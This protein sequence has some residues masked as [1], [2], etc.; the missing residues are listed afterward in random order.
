MIYQWK[1]PGVVPVDAQ[2]AGEELDRICRERG[3]L[4]PS[5]IVDESRP[6]EAPLHPC[7]EWDDTVAA[8][9]YREVQASS[10]VRNIT[11]THEEPSGPQNIR[12]FVHVQGAYQP[13]ARVLIDPV[14]TEELFRTAERELKAFRDKYQTLE[15]LKPVFDAIEEVTA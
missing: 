12:A 10:I 1:L 2:T 5:Y 6:E 3:T 14:K 7:F 9:K 13:I 8:E 11:V 15:R 4:N